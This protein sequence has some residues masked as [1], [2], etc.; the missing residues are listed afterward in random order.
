MRIGFRTVKTAVGTTISVFLAQ[1]LGLQFVVSAGMLTIL[2]MQT[3][4]RKSLETAFSRFGAC[5]VAIIVGSFL[6]SVLGHHVLVIG[7]TLLV[8]IPLT[9]RF[10]VA[11]GIGT[12]SV[13]MLQIYNATVIDFALIVELF[14][15]VAVGIGVALI[16]NFYMPSVDKE[17]EGYQRQV[18]E[19]FRRM[20]HMM[21]QAIR[22]E[23]V[24]G[25]LVEIRKAEEMVKDAKKLGL[26]ELQNYLLQPDDT[27]YQYFSAKEKQLDVIKRVVPIIDTL[28]ST[29]EQNYIIADFLDSI[30]DSMRPKA[31]ESITLLQL[32]EMRQQFRELPLPKT[33]EEFENR[34]YLMQFVY[35]MEQY[36]LIKRTYY[37]KGLAQA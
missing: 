31:T 22:G 21:A 11:G 18:E 6:F 13:V 23:D 29:Y 32:Q 19:Q 10:K 24:Q 14:A 17:L 28:S 15:L 26:R 33:M 2:C 12:S 37:I 25:G 27:Y 20:F 8:V 35:E 5:I 7:L 36:L 9:V 30:A 1:I 16:I 34:A 3:T 4:R